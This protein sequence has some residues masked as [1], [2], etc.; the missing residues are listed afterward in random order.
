[1]YITLHRRSNPDGEKVGSTSRGGRVNVGGNV[2]GLGLTS[3]FTD[4]SAEMVTAV[5]PLYL[6]FQLRLTSVQFGIIDG[7]TQAVTALTLIFG[8][9]VADRFRRY[10]EVAATG[11]AVSAGC[12]L[13]LLAVGSA[14]VPTAGMLFLDRTGKGLRTAPRDSLISL[15]AP[16]GRIGA[17][18]G[19]HRALDTIGAV[20]GPFVA[21]LILLAAP[22]AYGSVF[23]I[24]FCVALIGLAILVVFVNGGRPDRNPLRPAGMSFQ[25]IGRLAKAPGLRR[26]LAAAALLNLLTISDAF[27]Y[28]TLQHR[29]SLQTSFFPLL[30]LG[31]AVTYLLLAVPFGR[32]AD[33][34]G[35]RSVVVGGYL[36]LLAAY[37]SLL[38]S[39]P[40]PVAVVAA[41]A[42]SAPSTRRRM[43]S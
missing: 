12:K 40:G 29:S 25:A 37:G 27:I 32:L 39:D 14:W 7:L 26:I 18:F 24:S 38:V 8:A 4:V 13:G 31:T 6:T 19:V 36:L 33:R 23:V 22:G 28:L 2:I 15:S 35:S 10:K 11:Y 41:L 30:F 20:L 1:V 42:L 21:F 5:L 3:L 34:I 9:V 16:P 43:G 17:A